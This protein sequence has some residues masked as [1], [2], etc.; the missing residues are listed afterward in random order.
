M[1]GIATPKAMK[2]MT[3]EA[4]IAQLKAKV[5]SPMTPSIWMKPKSERY[6]ITPGIIG[7]TE[8]IAM[9]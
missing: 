3:S 2:R 7:M 8:G 9:T 4:L 1:F 6:I 5:S